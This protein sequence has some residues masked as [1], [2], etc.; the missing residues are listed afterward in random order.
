MCPPNLLSL[1]RVALTPLAA[2]TILHYDY[3]QALGV[4]AAAGITDALDG[5]VARRF[6]WSTRL[7]TLLDPIADKIFAASVFLSLGFAELLPWWLVGTVFGRDLLILAFSGAAMVFSGR[8]DFRPS[9]WG[10]ISTAVQIVTALVVLAAGVASYAAVRAAASGLVWLTAAA[11]IWSGLH[12]A[13]TGWRTFR[14]AHGQGTE[15]PD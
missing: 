6:G 9:L 3:D 8:R 11:T 10:K 1:A 2:R 15:V 4:C 7:G 12:Y 14:G 13:W 5:M